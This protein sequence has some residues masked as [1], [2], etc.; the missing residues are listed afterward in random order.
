INGSGKKVSRGAISRHER[1]GVGQV[2][3][4]DGRGD[5]AVATV[6]FYSS[7]G[8]VEVFANDPFVRVISS[9]GG[10]K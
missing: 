2:L 3:S 5:E 1:F 9:E 10:A 6:Q 7:A 8:R 4:I